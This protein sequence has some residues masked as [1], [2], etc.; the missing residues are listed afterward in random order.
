MR[1]DGCGDMH[2][3]VGV[4]PHDDLLCH[5]R[6]GH[7]LPPRTDGWHRWAS[8]HDC[9]GTSG[10]APM[11]SR[12]FHRRLSVLGRGLTDLREGTHWPAGDWVKL[13]PEARLRLRCEGES[14]SGRRGSTRD[15]YLGKVRLS[16]CIREGSKMASRRVLTPNFDGDP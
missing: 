10:Q 6:P 8:G 4:H 15:P 13:S 3:L 1:V 12:S 2:V 5:A 16:F 11:R 14:D 7:R 9:Y